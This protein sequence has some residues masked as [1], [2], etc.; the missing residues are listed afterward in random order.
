MT[1]LMTL[2]SASKKNLYKKN[3]KS[4]KTYLEYLSLLVIKPLHRKNILE[5]FS[6]LI[7]E[8]KFKLENSL[9]PN[10]GTYAK[11]L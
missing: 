3:T 6:V 9:K 7:F 11:L 1:S 8:P 5:P 10:I 4:N 2:Y